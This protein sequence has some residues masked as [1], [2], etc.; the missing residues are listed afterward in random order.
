MPTTNTQQPRLLTP[1]ELAM[2]VK[3]FREMRQWSQEQLGEISGLSARTVQRVEDGQGSSLDTRRALARAFE[4]EDID[5]FN[6]PYAIP[7]EGEMKAAKEKFDRENITIS[8][9]PLATGKELAG[10]VEMTSMDLS[11]PAFDLSR[12]ADEKF[13]ELIDYFR[14]YRDCAECYAQRDKFA[15]YDALQEYIDAL[16]ELHVSL[17]YATRKMV[18]KGNPPDTNPVPVTVLYVIAFPLGKE[19]DEFATPRNLPVGW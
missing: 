2:L 9:L 10:L 4:L 17:R 14:D 3:L 18:V 13:A 5:A 12:E 19:P 1:K 15:I 16:K 11:T 6:K 8:A 7:T